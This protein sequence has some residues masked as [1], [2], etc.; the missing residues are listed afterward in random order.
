[1]ALSPSSRWLSPQDPDFA[2]VLSDL[3]SREMLWLAQGQLKITAET[4]GRR[5]RQITGYITARKSCDSEWQGED[6]EASL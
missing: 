6:V 4:E 1:M 2:E 3:S 5:L